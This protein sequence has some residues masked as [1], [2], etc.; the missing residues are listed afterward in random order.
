MENKPIIFFFIGKMGAGKSTFSK[1]L[2]QELKAIFISEDEWLKE[3]YPVEIDTF[4]E[5]AKYSARIKP[6]L[7]QHIQ[8][9][10]KSGSTIVMD[11]PGN[12]RKQRAWFKEIIDGVDCLSQ[13]IYLKADDEVCLHR[14]AERRE[15]MP[16]R[17]NFD[18]EE[19]FREV[20]SYFEEPSEDEGFMIEV[21]EQTL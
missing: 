19:V 12:T 14:L 20:T 21:I 1:V 4:T 7:K 2:S 11:F 8:S 16:E 13:I 17:A 3:L 9:I 5:Y 15:A 6:L 18:S 10:L